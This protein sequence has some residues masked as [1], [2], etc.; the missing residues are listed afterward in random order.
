MLLSAQGIV[1]R[2]Y[3]I[4]FKV[5]SL[6]DGVPLQA[7]LKEASTNIAKRKALYDTR[8]QESR[9]Q[10]CGALNAHKSHL[11]SLRCVSTSE[12]KQDLL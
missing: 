5:E 3:Q 7:V 4:T 8:A 1:L 2:M 9:T 11:S 12:A 6:E 10:D